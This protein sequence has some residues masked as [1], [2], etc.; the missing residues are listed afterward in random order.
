MAYDDSWSPLADL[1]VTMAWPQPAAEPFEPWTP[2][3]AMSEAAQ[4]RWA[5]LDAYRGDDAATAAALRTQQAVKRRNMGGELSPEAAQMLSDLFVPHTV[6]DAA[7]FM[8]GGILTK[9]IVATL[10]PSEAKAGP[11]ATVRKAAGNAGKQIINRII[12]AEPSRYVPSW[13]SEPILPGDIR[14]STRLPTSL[15]ALEDPLKHHLNV[16][17]TEALATPGFARNLQMMSDY[18]GLAFMKDLP[19]EEAARAYID[20]GRRNLNFIYRNAPAAIRQRSPFWA[21]GAHEFADTLAQRY[22]IPIQSVGGAIAT[23]SP[24]TRWSANA[25]RAERVG[26]ILFGSTSS[27]PMTL[28]MLALARS[29]PSLMSPANADVVRRI[30]GKSLSQLTDPSEQAIWTRLY[31]EVHNPRTFRTMTPEG[32]IGDVVLSAS[33]EPQR[34]SWGRGEDIAKAVQSYQSGGDMNIISP[35]LG[36]GTRCEAF[37]M[38]SCCPT[39]RVSWAT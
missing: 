5:A 39:T 30:T 24:Q 7:M 23:L 25:S 32:M 8:P 31:D 38:T 36:A 1:G 28:D 34:L 9:A 2:L 3:P 11:I 22:G 29:T 19:A 12:G 4:R 15:R 35:L 17:L 27:H 33:G 16:G 20:F 6:A 13:T 37:T 18:P 10:W 26:D 14:A 21:E